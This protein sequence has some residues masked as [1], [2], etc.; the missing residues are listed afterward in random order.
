L[1]GAPR[2]VRVGRGDG[3][4]ASGW[5][6]PG[7]REPRARARQT[8]LRDEAGDERQAVRARGG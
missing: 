3:S 5:A 6:R 7:S 1:S 4:G 8:H 2:V